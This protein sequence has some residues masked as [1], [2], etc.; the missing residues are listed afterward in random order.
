METKSENENENELT[1]RDWKLI[2]TEAKEVSFDKNSILI[3]Q[4]Q[5]NSFLYQLKS[6]KLLVQKTIGSFSSPPSSLFI[7]LLFLL[8]FIFI[9][10]ILF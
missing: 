10:L 4:N 8:L 6:G 7:F 1:E 2:L 9:I 3:Q 5:K